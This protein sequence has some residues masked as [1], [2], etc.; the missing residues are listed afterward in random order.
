MTKMPMQKVFASTYFYCLICRRKNYL[1][2]QILY[3]QQGYVDAK[4]SFYWSVTG[5]F[6]TRCRLVAE[7][8]LAS[9]TCFMCAAFE[10][11]FSSS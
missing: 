2:L 4:V 5:D 6:L 7:P 10:F 8:N 11:P 3:L 9:N 1:Q